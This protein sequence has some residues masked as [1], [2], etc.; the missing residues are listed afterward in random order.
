MPD[1]LKPPSIILECAT[2]LRKWWCFFSHI[3][4]KGRIL[5]EWKIETA[6][7]LHLMRQMFPIHA[8]LDELEP[9]LRGVNMRRLQ[10]AQALLFRVEDDLI[11]SRR[12]IALAAEAESESSGRSPSD[13]PIK[14][15]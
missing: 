2:P 12:L 8:E 6:D 4:F 10:V 5:T 13:N 14:I 7:R 11:K 1:D 15:F 3:I 9:E